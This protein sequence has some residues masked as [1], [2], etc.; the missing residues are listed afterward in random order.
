MGV[1]LGKDSPQVTL[2]E[3]QDA[4]GEFV[5]GCQYESFGEA[6]G[7]RRQLHLISTIGIAVCV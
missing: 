2:A 3:D 5:P 6:V 1:V 7:P 4:V